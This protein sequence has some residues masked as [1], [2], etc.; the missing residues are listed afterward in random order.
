MVGL[1]AAWMLSMVAPAVLQ[2][3]YGFQQFAVG[4]LPL[5]GGWL[6]QQLTN[7]SV[8]LSQGREY[9]DFGWSLKRED[10]LARGCRFS[11]C[12]HHKTPRPRQYATVSARPDLAAHGLDDEDRP[13]Y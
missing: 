13:L 11:F 10:Y 6:V 3:D 2:M 12:L 8:P 5:P 1:L 7:A 9:A 4:R